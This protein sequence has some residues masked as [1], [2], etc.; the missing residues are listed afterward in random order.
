VKGSLFTIILGL[1]LCAMAEEAAQVQLKAH[2]EAPSKANI[3][4]G[5]IAEF[6]GLNETEENYLKKIELADTP[7]L[8]EKRV[9]T[10]RGLS[11]VLRAH[12]AEMGH[13]TQKKVSLQI[14]R[15]VVVENKNP[16]ITA[17][18]LA[19]ALQKRW[20][21][22]CADCEYQFRGIRAPAIANNVSILSW[23]LRTPI[24]S[25]KGTFT[26]GFDIN[27]K[28]GTSRTFWMTGQANIYKQVA[29]AQRTI[30]LG[31]RLQP[32]DF[33]IQRKDISFIRDGLAVGGEILGQNAKRAILADSVILKN[34]L[35]RE[36]AVLRGETVRVVLNDSS[37]EV[38]VNGVAE[39]DAF[40][41][42]LISV[43]NPKNQYMMSGKVV[44]R[45]I[46]EMK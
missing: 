45:G 40:V 22:N 8:G 46:V 23:N 33:K 14:P 21:E 42:D 28:D 2:N 34:D 31:E 38:S 13:G 39:K 11:E 37:F 30:A 43:R 9:F 5:D 32:E 35:E 44:A 3:T 16:D 24:A 4:L 41:G 7:S 20:L 19:I 12:L 25:P 27:L 18:N 1:G 26:Q 10:S 36:K 6:V 15:E 17:E 29:V